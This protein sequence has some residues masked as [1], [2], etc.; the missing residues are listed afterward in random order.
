MTGVFESWALNVEVTQGYWS[1]GEEALFPKPS[2]VK[3]LCV[4]SVP[5]EPDFRYGTAT[6][7]ASARSLQPGKLTVT[8]G[9]TIPQW[10]LLS[11]GQAR[12]AIL[13][14][15]AAP[16]PPS[17]AVDT[18]RTWSGDAPPPGPWSGDLPLPRTLVRGHSTTQAFR[19]ETLHHTVP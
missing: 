8:M 3:D 10:P 18:L 13:C 5:R 7:S 19:Q 11:A 9:R 17:S 1:L 14:C 15:C 12:Q 16:A 4:E 2:R 6:P